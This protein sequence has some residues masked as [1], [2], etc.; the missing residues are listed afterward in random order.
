[1][2]MLL[3]HMGIAESHLSIAFAFGFLTSKARYSISPLIALAGGCCSWHVARCYNGLS[4]V[5]SLREC[6]A[7]RAVEKGRLV[8][9]TTKQTP[10]STYS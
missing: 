1:M 7:T 9:F 5:I 8:F 3:S 2:R 10:E 6:S 4:W